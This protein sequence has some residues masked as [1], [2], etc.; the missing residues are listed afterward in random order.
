MINGT[1]IE[2]L[3]DAKVCRLFVAARFA[4]ISK[5]NDEL[6]TLLLWLYY[7]NPYSEFNSIIEKDCRI[8]EIDGTAIANLNSI[9]I[10][11]QRQN[12]LRK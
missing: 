8:C 9:S 2:K 3:C 5:Q 4:F 6:C 12:R 7:D 1:K 10:D 11:L